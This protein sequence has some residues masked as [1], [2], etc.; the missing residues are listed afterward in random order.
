MPKK[1][2][3]NAYYFFMQDFREEQRKKGVNYG[4]LQEVAKAAD[5][6]WRDAP[7]PVRAKYEAMAKQAK[8]KNN[9]P[10]KKYTSTGISL[11]EIDQMQM[12]QQKAEEDEVKDIKSFVKLN[13]FSSNEALIHADIYLMDVNYYCQAGTEFI[14]GECTILR[15]NLIDGIKD[16]YHEVINPDRIPPG[17]VSDIKI[18]CEEYGLDMPDSSVRTSNYFQILALTIDYLKQDR[19]HGNNTLPPVYTMPDKVAPVTNFI[20]QMCSRASEYDRLFRVYKLDTLFYHMINA[21]KS[22][23]DEGFPKP[24]LALTQL[25]KD[26]FK[27]NPGLG[28]ESH[29]K[30]DK[31]VECTLSR[32]QRWAYTILDSVCPVAGIEALPGC[33]VPKEFHV[34]SILNFKEQRKDRVGPSVAGSSG[35]MISFNSSMSDSYA[36]TSNSTVVNKSNTSTQSKKSQQPM[37]MPKTDYSAALRPAPELTESD[38]LSASFA[39]AAIAGRGRGRGLPTNINKLGDFPKLPNK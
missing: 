22:H 34:D 33:H 1:P 37:R 25:K 6:F 21:L 13:S 10:E 14:I 18:G 7:P 36:D 17:Y 23:E 16:N 28:C 9:V 29:E 26:Q 19:S 35:A 12:E 24:S 11:A 39:Q 3:Q 15:F 20:Q 38:L 8:M 31:S 32:T 5:P 2:P 4:N 30:K 27:Y